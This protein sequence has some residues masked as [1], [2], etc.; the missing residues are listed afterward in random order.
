[1]IE[2]LI[3]EIFERIGHTWL[4]GGRHLLPNSSDITQVL[5]KAAGSLYDEPEGTQF[6]T[7]GLII[8]KAEDGY[9]VYVCVGNFE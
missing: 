3:Q 5:D 8:E 1:M 4:I 7:G 6:Q 9:D 2:D